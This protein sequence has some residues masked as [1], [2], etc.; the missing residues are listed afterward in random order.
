MPLSHQPL[1]QSH[2]QQ[3][4]QQSRQLPS[5]P[6]HISICFWQSVASKQKRTATVQ[7]YESWGVI[8]NILCYVHLRKDQALAA[9][10]C[11]HQHTDVNLSIYL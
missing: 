2:E 5:L 3:L 7:L 11:N 9:S 10:A 4:P 6:T 8:L 1:L